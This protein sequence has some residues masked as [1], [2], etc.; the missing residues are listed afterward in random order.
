MKKGIVGILCCMLV[1]F[2]LLSLSGVV[3]ASPEF[4]LNHAPVYIGKIWIDITNTGNETAFNISWILTLKTLFPPISRWNGTIGNL[5]V[6]ETKRITTDGFLFGFGFPTI[7]L[8]LTAAN[9][10]PANFIGRPIFI[11]G[12]FI[13]WPRPLLPTY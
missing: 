9:A 7:T 12:P 6:N 13:I 11:I 4:S 1:M 5:S 8:N 2:P 3:G 10:E